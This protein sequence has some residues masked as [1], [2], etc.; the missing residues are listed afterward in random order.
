MTLWPWTPTS[1][2]PVGGGRLPQHKGGTPLTPILGPWRY[3]A[4]RGR[5]PAT[6][7]RPGTIPL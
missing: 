1:E 6:G 4:G 3:R 5:C 7:I 2:W